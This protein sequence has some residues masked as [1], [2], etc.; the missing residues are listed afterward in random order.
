MS[1]HAFTEIM[2]DEAAFLEKHDNNETPPY[3]LK[4]YSMQDWIHYAIVG[5][6][7]PINSYF[8][9]GPENEESEAGEPVWWF[10]TS[11][12]EVPTFAA[13]CSIIRK[14]FGNAVEFEFVDRI[15]RD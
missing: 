1:R 2:R 13:L 7:A 8:L 5:W 3:D 6:D 10:G 9:Q 11:Y 12:A 4:G 15:D 14:I